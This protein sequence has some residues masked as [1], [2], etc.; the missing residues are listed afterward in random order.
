[1]LGFLI[2]TLIFIGALV[3]FSK[4]VDIQKVKDNWETYRCRPDVMLMADY[5][6][7][8]S[9]ENLQYCLKN[10]FDKR[11]MEAIAPF[12]TYLG[13]FVEVLMTM[14]NSINSIR[15]IF[16]TIIGS[17]TQI[18]TEFSGRIQALFYRFQMAAIRMKMLMGRVFATMYAVI[19]MGM[20]GIKATQN[21]GNTFLFKF[22]DTFCF[23]PDTEIVL[24]NGTRVPIK[25]VK[26]GDYLVG[27]Q[28]V[29]AAFQF[30]ADGQ[31]M[32]SLPLAATEPKG[33][34]LPLAATE[35]KGVKLSEILVS[36]NHYIKY[37]GKWIEAK[38]HPDARAAADWSGGNDRPLIC[39]NTDTHTIPIGN[40]IF[41]DYDETSEGDESAMKM[42]TDILNGKAAPPQKGSS[43]MA[44]GPKTLIKTVFGLVPADQITLGTVLSHGTV[45]GL[46]K[47]ECRS[48][49]RINGETFAAGTCIWSPEHN[50]WL[51]AFQLSKPAIM[52]PLIF[53][54]FVVTPS[55]TIE[56]Q[57]TVFRDYVEVHSKDL[58]APY[59]AAINAPFKTKGQSEC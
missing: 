3:G 14:L 21:F 26:V 19:F 47:K 50:R 33:V 56:T 43:D 13:K 58:E 32:V 44:C 10:G 55:A 6:G 51:R 53:Y 16:A 8:D 30:A 24:Q 35:P 40:Y 48:I 39:L 34:S 12:Y 37:K 5:Y 46:V 7:H 15:M 25:E 22:L 54:S 18:F 49:C 1:M 57:K 9:I 31:A 38:D 28:R 23:D 29:T 59:S 45:V 41:S 27:G 52:S 4:I 17:A 11:A 20:A 42:A 36:T 2:V